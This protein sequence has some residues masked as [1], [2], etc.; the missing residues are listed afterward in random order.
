MFCPLKN[1]IICWKWR[2]STRCTKDKMIG[3][4]LKKKYLESNKYDLKSSIKIIGTKKCQMQTS[5]MEYFFMTGMKN[6]LKSN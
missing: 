1:K 3:L 2:L 6:R 4:N 5:Q